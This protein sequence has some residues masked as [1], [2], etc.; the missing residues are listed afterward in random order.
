MGMEGDYRWDVRHNKADQEED[1]M[2]GLHIEI[3]NLRKEADKDGHT[4][5]CMADYEYH[6]CYDCPTEFECLKLYIKEKKEV[7]NGRD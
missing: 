5:F 2:N 4:G 6:T 7:Q 1:T 3:D